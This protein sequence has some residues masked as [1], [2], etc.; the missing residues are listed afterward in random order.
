MKTKILCLSVVAALL[1]LPVFVAAQ[2]PPV[3]AAPLSTQSAAQAAPQPLPPAAAI[4]PTPF[5]PGLHVA[6]DNM[7]P[8][9]EQ[10]RLAR[11]VLHELLMLPY[12]NVFDWLTFRVDGDKVE[13]KG[14]THSLGLSRDAE[15]TVK[16]IKGVGKVVNHIE[17]LP[18]SPSDERI[19]REVAQAVF[20]FSNLGRYSWPTDTRIHIIVNMGHVRLEGMVDTKEDKQL[21]F[22]RANGVPGTF[23]VDNNLI[24]ARY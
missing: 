3:D 10:E 18:P 2:Q 23:A 14:Y 22:I 16:H 6:K 1:E 5:I 21:A 13:L 15:R 4:A 12:Y 19:R 20:S 8:A 11:A 24:V 7:P 9:N 17:E